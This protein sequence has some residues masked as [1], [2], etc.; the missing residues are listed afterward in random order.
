MGTKLKSLSMLNLVSVASAQPL[1]KV[2]GRIKDLIVKLQ[3]EAAEAASM[4][5][6]CNAEK[7]KNEEATKKATSKRD[8]LQTTID[9]SEARKEE[10]Q[11]LITQLRTEIA[12]IEASNVEAEKLRNEQHENFVKSEADFSE[13]ADAVQE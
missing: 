7:K 5:E 2:K 4:H 6:F 11:D 13:A 8:E 12:E 10:L 9:K 3:K 1:D